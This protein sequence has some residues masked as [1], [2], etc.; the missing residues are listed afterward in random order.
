MTATTATTLG[1]WGATSRWT[2]VGGPVHYADFGGPEGASA[3]ADEQVPRI[4]LVHGLGGSHL[5]WMLVGAGLARHARVVAPDLVGFGHTP[6]A[7]RKASIRAQAALLDRFVREVAGGPALLVG[8][9]MGGMI[10]LL[11][12][13]ANPRTVTGVVGVDAV[14]PLIPSARVEPMVATGFGALAVP[15]V[16]ERLLARNQARTP[17]SAMVRGVLRLVCADPSRVP[18]PLVDALVGLSEE[19]S[20]RDGLERAYLQATRSL[21]GVLS[22]PRWYRRRLASITAPVMLLTGDSDR[23]VPHGG[24]Q[25]LAARHPEWKLVTYPGVGHVPQLEVPEDVVRSVVDWLARGRPE[26]RGG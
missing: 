1:T 17:P 22:R 4:V 16:G 5:D 20:G 3:A 14:V 19:R 26:E 10:S 2:D 15:G 25:R 21:L 12:A 24:A 8:N 13:A 6:V 9:S 23:L 7:G 18:P 11:T